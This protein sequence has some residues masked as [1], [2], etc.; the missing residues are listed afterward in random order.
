MFIEIAEDDWIDPVAVDRVRLSTNEMG[1]SFVQL[2]LSCGDKIDLSPHIELESVLE[3]LNEGKG[4]EP[5]FGFTPD[6]LYK[7]TGDNQG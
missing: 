7:L 1:A 3:T 6:N 2:T 5:I 4:P